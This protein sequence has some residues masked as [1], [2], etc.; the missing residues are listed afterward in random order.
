MTI[1]FSFTSTRNSEFLLLVVIESNFTTKNDA[2][3]SRRISR[4]NKNETGAKCEMENSKFRWI[5]KFHLNLLH[6]LGEERLRHM[7]QLAYS[8]DSHVI[9]ITFWYASNY[10]NDDFSS[11]SSFRHEQRKVGNSS[12][13]SHRKARKIHLDDVCAKI[14][15]ARHICEVFQAFQR[16]INKFLVRIKD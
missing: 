2:T 9:T 16:V 3:K 7:A 13:S 15:L 8:N 12:S 5:L 1:E 6:C 14:R 11:S 10:V 4:R